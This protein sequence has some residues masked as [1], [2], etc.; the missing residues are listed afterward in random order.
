MLKIVSQGP[1]LL[2]RR[3]FIRQPMQQRVDLRAPGVGSGIPST[4]VDI[5]GGGCRITTRQML[6]PRS[7]VEFELPN[8]AP[9]PITLS[10]RIAKVRYTP[11]DRTFH[12]GI[13]FEAIEDRERDTLLR[14]IGEEH[15]RL[16]EE[17]RLRRR[18]E[19]SRAPEHERRRSPRVTTHFSLVYAVSGVPTSFTAHALDIGTGGIRVYTDRLIRSDWALELRLNLPNDVLRMALQVAGTLVKDA[20]PFEPM[21]LSARTLP[22]ALRTREGYVQRLS[23]VNVSEPHAAELAR[24]VRAASA[25]VM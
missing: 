18:R 17:L 25:V 3:A 20:R 4:L 7:S 14:F 11:A 15:R 23:F 10:G 13:A 16:L 5:S 1:S 19:S 2:N 9:D 6:K 24:F 22:G 21:R 8:V 12:Y